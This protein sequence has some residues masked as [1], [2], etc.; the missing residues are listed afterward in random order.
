[1]KRKKQLEK[2][3]K[4]LKWAIYPS[5]T[6]FPNSEDGGPGPCS[7]RSLKLV[8]FNKASRGPESPSFKS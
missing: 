4:S 3:K 6:L 5:T 1:M 8:V 7:H 2:G